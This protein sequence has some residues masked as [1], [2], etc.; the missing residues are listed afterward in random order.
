[1]AE[2]LAA[3]SAYQGHLRGLALG[4]PPLQG[5]ADLAGR[6]V[7]LALRGRALKN[8]EDH[9]CRDLRVHRAVRAPLGRGA[10]PLLRRYGGGLHLHAGATDV[11][12]IVM[13]QPTLLPPLIGEGG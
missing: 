5:Q 9:G 3:W 10:L 8:Y 7:L 2:R 12:A 13:V 1:M 6:D 4:D 11:V